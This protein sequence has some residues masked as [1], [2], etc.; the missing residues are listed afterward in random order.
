MRGLEV[1]A[2]RGHTKL[3]Q[4]LIILLDD[5]SFFSVGDIAPEAQF[6]VIGSERDIA[7]IITE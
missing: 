3:L 2:L 1:S 4:Q 5:E 6:V 7:L